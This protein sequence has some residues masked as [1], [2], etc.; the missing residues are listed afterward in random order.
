[1]ESEKYLEIIEAAQA[2]GK[3]RRGV[4][5]VTK[6]LERGQAKLVVAA[7]DVSPKEIIMHLPIIAKEK[8][9]LYGEVASREELGAASGLPR[10]TTAVAVIDAG[11]AKDVLKALAKETEA[12]AKAAATPAKEEA[13]EEAPVAEEKAEEKAEEPAKEAAPEAEKATEEKKE[14]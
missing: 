13:K 9:V 7:S 6:V 3:V 12:A 5:E 11:T 1:M 10:A 14:E 8:G 2:S 4:N